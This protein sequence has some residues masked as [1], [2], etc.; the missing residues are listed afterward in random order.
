MRL[1][2]LVLVAAHRAVAHDSW[3]KFVIKS[4]RHDP[5]NFETRVHAA[6]DGALERLH[7]LEHGFR[8]PWQRGSRDRELLQTTTGDNAWRRE[9]DALRLLLQVWRHRDDPIFL[10]G[11]SEALA[12]LANDARAIDELMGR[13]AES[14]RQ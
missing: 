4:A 14:T 7:A 3:H 13:L 10:P 6:L 2:L 8:F 11:A 9:G 1:V 12:E 5:I